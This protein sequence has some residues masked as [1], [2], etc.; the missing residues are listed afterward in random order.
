[1]YKRIRL[2]VCSVLFCCICTNA[3][4]IDITPYYL[5]TNKI[6][7]N[8]S[9]VNGVAICSGSVEPAKREHTASVTVSLQEYRGGWSTI[10][11]WGGSAGAGKTA[12]ASGSKGVS[13]GVNYRVVVSGEIKD[14]NRNV[15]ERPSKTSGTKSY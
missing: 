5:Y 12:S 9:I 10:E 11:S 4:A 3:L 13:A 8:F 14:A 6:T 7:N 2:L 15:I 1:M